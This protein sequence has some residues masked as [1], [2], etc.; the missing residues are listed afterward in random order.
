MPNQLQVIKQ[1]RH[2][3][4]L[5]KGYNK[6]QYIRFNSKASYNAWLHFNPENARQVTMR[7]THLSLIL[8]LFWVHVSHIFLEPLYSSL[9]SLFLFLSLVT[10]IIQAFMIIPR[11]LHESIFLPK[12]MVLYNCVQQDRDILTE[13][14]LANQKNRGK[15]CVQNNST[16]LPWEHIRLLWISAKPIDF[17]LKTNVKQVGLAGDSN[18][19]IFGSAHIIHLKD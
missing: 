3:E 17:T 19:S 11:L 14:E 4:I 6:T 7:K 13:V 16:P 1:I 8:T 9:C 18:W 5:K 2:D 15:A 10:S 12:Y